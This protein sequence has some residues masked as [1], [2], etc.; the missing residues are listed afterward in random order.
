MQAFSINPQQIAIVRGFEADLVSEW[1]A[2]FTTNFLGMPLTNYVGVA[3]MGETL[4]T[5]STLEL[6]HDSCQEGTSVLALL[7]NSWT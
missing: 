5:T 4:K 7:R 6:S 3:N 1:G 2:T